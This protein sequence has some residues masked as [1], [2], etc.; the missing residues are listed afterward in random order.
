MDEASSALQS[1]AAP[2]TVLS[3]EAGDLQDQY[4]ELCD[5]A[6]DLIDILA[7]DGKV[8]YA[9]AAWQKALGYSAEEVSRLTLW[10]VVHPDDQAQSREGIRRLLAGYEPPRF[11]VRFRSKTGATI[12]LEGTASCRRQAGKPLLI[13]G[14]LRDVGERKRA[15]RELHE[16][17]QRLQTALKREREI[18]RID[19]LTQVA[20]RRAF[21][22]MAEVELARA[23]RSR[24]PLSFACVDIDDFKKVNDALGHLTGDAVLVSI[25]STLRGSVRSTDIV[26][27]MGGDEFQIILSDTDANAAQAVLGKLRRALL[28]SVESNGWPVTFS[29]GAASFL[30][31]PSSIE[32]A[33]RLADDAMYS[34]KNRDKNGVAVAMFA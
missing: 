11:E 29:I 8:L 27:R 6:N 33:V 28:Q 5:S 21:Y 25:A 13:R 17:H 18:A 1:P 3:F 9:N 32:E 2:E 16:V 14:I 23:R 7:A 12:H 22:E 20:N 15:E 10:D 31:P 34:V 30:V 24:K 4:K 19:P 26:A